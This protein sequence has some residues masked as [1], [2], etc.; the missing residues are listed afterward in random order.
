[1]FGGP[2][3]E[4]VLKRHAL[5]LRSIT[6]PTLALT[7]ACSNSGTELSSAASQGNRGGSAGVD[8]SAPVF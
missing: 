3:L 4:S 6:A 2:E 5:A 7:L 1:M 8:G